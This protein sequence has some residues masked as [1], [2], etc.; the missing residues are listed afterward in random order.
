M[1]T[2]LREDIA[3]QSAADICA[4]IAAGLDAD[5]ETKDLAPFWDALAAKGDGLA[6]TR[7]TL[8]RT[9]GR[10]RA[11]VG[12]L[13]A[14]WDSEAGAFARDVL[15]ESHGRRDLAPNTRFFASVPAS[16]AQTF[17]IDREVKEARRWILELGRDP[18]EALADRW[19]ARL[20]HATDALEAAGKDRSTAMSPLAMHG[21]TKTLYV[22]EINIELDKLEGTLKQRFP[23]Q[24]KRISAYLEPT[25]PKRSRKGEDGAEGNGDSGE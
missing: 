20:T 15:N 14:L 3:A 5:S 12:V 24:P 6:A 8:E 7:R 4:D 9:V 13:D 1:A 10:A 17:G 16:E 11:R 22:E 2:H 18:S 23:R 21:T 19:I 25:K